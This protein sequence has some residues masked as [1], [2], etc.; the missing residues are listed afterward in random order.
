MVL[1]YFIWRITMYCAAWGAT[2]PESLAM[3]NPPVPPAAVIRV[4]QEVRTGSTEAGRAGLVGVGAAVGVV[5]GGAI[6]SMFK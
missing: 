5:I 4:R 2:T 6:R 3:M 1:F